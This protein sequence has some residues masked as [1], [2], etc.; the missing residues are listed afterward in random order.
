MAVEDRFR[1]VGDDFKLHDEV[2]VVVT[3]AV[4][5]GEP[6]AVVFWRPD[7]SVAHVEET[8]PDAVEEALSFAKAKASELRRQVVVQLDDLD[9]WWP[10][11]GV[12]G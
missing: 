9:T 2:L 1:K 3:D 4:G 10:R 12:L 7:A 5:K 6:I 11:W 8:E